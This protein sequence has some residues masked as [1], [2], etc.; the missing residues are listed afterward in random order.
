MTE[1]MFRV[2]LETSNAKADKDGWS[3]LPEGRQMTLYAAH[4]GVSLTVA[5][6]EAVRSAGAFLKA[7][8]VKGDTFVLALED[9]FA[10][11]FDAGTESPAARKAGFLG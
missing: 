3:A 1:E 10:T 7:R 6:V 11:A 4:N 8:T 5:K 9:V 2:V